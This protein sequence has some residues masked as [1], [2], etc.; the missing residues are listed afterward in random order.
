VTVFGLIGSVTTG[1]FGTNIPGFGEMPLAAQAPILLV[2]IGLVTV[3]LFYMLAKSKRLADFSRR[4]FR[5]AP[6]RAREVPNAARR[7][8]Q[9]GALAPRFATDDIKRRRRDMD[10]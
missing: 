5:R 1:I 6:S 8:A 10:A 4:H 3:L 2:T 7:A 9:E